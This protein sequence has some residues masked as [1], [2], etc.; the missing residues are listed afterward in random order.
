[1]DQAHDKVMSTEEKL[2]KKEILIE[3]IESDI[4]DKEES[5]RKKN[6]VLNQ[7]DQENSM[8]R[9]AIIIVLSVTIGMAAMFIRWMTK[10]EVQA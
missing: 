4:R 9:M 8:L 6:E 7:K 3:K 1:M 2:V 5:L 10:V